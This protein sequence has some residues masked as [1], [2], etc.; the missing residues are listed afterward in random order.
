LPPLSE[1]KDDKTTPRNHSE[2]EQERTNHP[3]APDRQAPA[4]TGEVVTLRPIYWDDVAILR[5]AGG[6]PE[7]IRALLRDQR[8]PL[9]TEMAI[10]QWVSRGRIANEFRPR[11]VYALLRAGKITFKD[12]FKVTTAY[13]GTDG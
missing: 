2:M 9:P 10:Y 8:Q 3:T 1:L 6:A 4:K 12:L 11:L 13:A 7:P 5:A